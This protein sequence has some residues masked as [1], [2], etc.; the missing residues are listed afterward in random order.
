[1]PGLRTTIKTVKTGCVYVFF[2]RQDVYGAHWG[3]CGQVHVLRGYGN[4]WQERCLVY[5]TT[6]TTRD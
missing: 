1:M 2:C 4:R 5:R 6:G 3:S